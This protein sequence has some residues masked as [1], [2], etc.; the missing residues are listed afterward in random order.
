MTKVFIS[1]AHDDKALADAVREL[2]TGVFGNHVAIGY[3]SDRS[4]GGGI[5]AG[6]EWFPWILGQVRE[7]DATIV[8]LTP[9]SVGKPWLMWEAGAVSGV[10]LSLAEKDRL[11]V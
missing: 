11:I 1:H 3:S 4:S 10:S 9:A 8:M 5:E 7:S 6:S 2:F